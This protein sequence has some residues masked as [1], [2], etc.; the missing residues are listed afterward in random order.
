MR[1]MEIV[2]FLLTHLSLLSCIVMALLTLRRRRNVQLVTAFF[3]LLLVLFIWNAG[4]LLELYWRIICGETKMLFIYL[5]YVGICFSPLAILYLGRVI[6]RL[7]FR[8]RPIH[9]LLAVIPCVS[10]A[11]ICTSGR[12]Q[13]FFRV[14]SLHSSEAVYGGYYY[15]HLLFSYGCIL[16]G[17]WY[18]IRFSARNSGTFSRQSILICMGILIPLAANVLYSFAPLDLTFGIRASMTTVTALCFALAFQRY[19]FLT[20]V[21]IAVQHIVDLISDGY[22]VIDGGMRIVGHNK[23]MLRLLPVGDGIPSGQPLEDFLA[24]HF[25]TGFTKTFQRMYGQSLVDRCTYS[26]ESYT[27]DSSDRK[28]LNVEITPVFRGKNHVGVIVLFKDIT[29]AK[30]ALEK[31]KEAQTVMIERERL[32]SLGQMVGGIAHNL[33]TP[34]LSIAGGV[35]A[36]RDLVREY[37]DSVGDAQ[38]TVEDHHEIAAE[39]GEWLERIRS[40]C[41]YISDMISTVKGQA[42]QHSAEQNSAFSVDEFIKRVELLMKHE[43][44]QSHCTLRTDIRVDLRSEI[45]GNVNSLVQIFANLILNSLHAYEGKKG[46]I[47]LGIRGE[48]GKLVFTLADYARGI[49]PEIQARLFR[50][51]VTTKGKNGTGLGLYLSH[52]TVKGLFHGK[53]AVESVPGEGTCFTISIPMR[54]TVTQPA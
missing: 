27:M 24:V 41:S 52:S 11:V 22:L 20:V 3:L 38:V 37:D 42:V 10:M 18:L 31:I 4:T 21:P 47:D 16:L 5:C 46:F 34:I 23:A 2:T 26:V 1:P 53:M 17:I 15:I 49:A 32:A 14:F 33:K 12:H 8:L 25:P 13:L 28:Y 36:L 39:M 7:D 6:S 50:E 40:H 45:G 9:G 51:M 29:Q 19:D 43:L 35:E 48:D 30:E 54:E 44:K